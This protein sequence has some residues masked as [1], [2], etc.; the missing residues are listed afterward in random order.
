MATMEYNSPINN[1]NVQYT[2]VSRKVK[3]MD[4][5]F[6]FDG[7]DLMT[8]MRDLERWY[9]I[10]VFV[11]G[12]LTDEKFIGMIPKLEDISDVLVLL[13]L[14]EK[15]KFKKNGRRITVMP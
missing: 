7:D 12:K 1:I 15:V 13:E 14:T 9:D 4:G 6:N 11:D 3:W 2:D 5:F 8:V 10:E